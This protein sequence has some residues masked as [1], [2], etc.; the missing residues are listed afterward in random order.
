MTSVHVPS[1]RADGVRIFLRPRDIAQSERRQHQRFPIIVQTQSILAGDGAQA[2]IV[3]ISSGAVF[4]KTNNIIQL[5][6]SIKVLI[7]WPVPLEQRC[8]LRLVIVGKVLRSN[9]TGTAVEIYAIGIWDF[10][11][12]PRLRSQLKDKKEHQ[13]GK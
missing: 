6:E 3:D 2:I 7:D 5:G 11:T 1:R 9:G 10:A 13:E 4:L 12:R 8:P